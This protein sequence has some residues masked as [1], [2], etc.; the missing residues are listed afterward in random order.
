[1][2]GVQ[3]AAENV[4]LQA[5]CNIA[6]E[7]FCGASGGCRLSRRF[8]QFQ[9]HASLSRILESTATWHAKNACLYAKTLL[10][11]EMERSRVQEAMK[12]FEV[13][14]AHFDRL[15][16]TPGLKWLGQNT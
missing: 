16:N 5:T 10:G 9:R 13:R 14:N 8:S 7:R 12:T 2:S 4:L 11:S 6:R 1:M 3:V 15:V